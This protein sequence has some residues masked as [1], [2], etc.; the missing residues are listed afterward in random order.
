MWEALKLT[1]D[2]VSNN[3]QT[4]LLSSA[5]TLGERDAVEVVQAALQVQSLELI[6]GL[7]PLRPLEGGE[8]ATTPERATIAFDGGVGGATGL[9]EGADAAVVFQDLRNSLVYLRG[10][11]SSLKFSH[12]HRERHTS[13]GRISNGF[14]LYCSTSVSAAT[15]RVYSSSFAGR[16]TPALVAGKY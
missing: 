7:G 9:H 11:V 2:D 3:L 6:I 14:G 4:L 16:Q 13:I 8:E 10:T 1:D 15:A 5:E 12:V